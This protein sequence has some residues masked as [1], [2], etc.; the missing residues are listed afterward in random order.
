M[1]YPF[2]TKEPSIRYPEYTKEL[3]TSIQTYVPTAKIKNQKTILLDNEEKHRAAKGII[4][5]LI[6]CIP[7]WI[8]VIKFFVWLI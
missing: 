7:F 4:Y 1:S 5:A 6:L 8:L 3:D 2:Y